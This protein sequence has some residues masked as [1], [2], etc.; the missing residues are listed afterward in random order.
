[1][2]T[3]LLSQSEIEEAPWNEEPPVEIEAT[4]SITISKPI[5]LIMSPKDEYTQEELIEEAKKQFP[6]PVEFHHWDIDDF[7]VTEE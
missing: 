3:P 2:N 7:A 4:V 6:L 1:M 5:T